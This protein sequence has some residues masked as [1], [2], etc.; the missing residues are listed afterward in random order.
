[1]ISTKFYLKNRSLALANDKQNHFLAD[2]SG[3]NLHREV[4]Q[5][6][7]AHSPL[8]LMRWDVT[9]DSEKMTARR[10]GK[11]YVYPLHATFQEAYQNYWRIFW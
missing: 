6:F 7:L 1:M 5:I 11:P 4:A 2:D 9:K 3:P 10:P 8:I